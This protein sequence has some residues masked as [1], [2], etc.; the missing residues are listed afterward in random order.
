MNPPLT[1]SFFRPIQSNTTGQKNFVEGDVES[2]AIRMYYDVTLREIVVI[3]RYLDNTTRGWQEIPFVLDFDGFTHAM[4]QHVVA[5]REMYLALK[6]YGGEIM[7]KRFERDLDAFDETVRD[8][9][10]Y[11]TEMRQRELLLERWCDSAEVARH[12]MTKFVVKDF[13]TNTMSRIFRPYIMVSYHA[14]QLYKF[15]DM[16]ITRLT[17]FIDRPPIARPL[18][19]GKTQVCAICWAKG[20]NWKVCALH[21]RDHRLPVSFCER[22]EWLHFIHIHLEAINETAIVPDGLTYPTYGFWVPFT[23]HTPQ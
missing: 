13:H 20:S 23:E 12:V 19:D 8:V 15:V 16:H 7:G 17:H 22:C 18:P 5:F 10:D 21:Y 2:E 9:K 3:R 14:Q 11:I 1:R 6:T 4:R